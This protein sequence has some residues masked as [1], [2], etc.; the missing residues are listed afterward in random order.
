MSID[1]IIGT[2][3]DS[4]VQPR[5]VESFKKAFASIN[6]SS[7]GGLT[8]DGLEQLYKKFDLDFSE[9]DIKMVLKILSKNKSNKSVTFEEFSKVFDER[10]TEDDGEAVFNSTFD[11]CNLDKTA[12][13]F[14]WHNHPTVSNIHE[15][16]RKKHIDKD[17]FKKVSQSLGIQLK[18]KDA[19]AM[20]G[21]IKNRAGFIRLMKT[22]REELEFWEGGQQ[23]ISQSIQTTSPAPPPP[24]KENIHR[25]V[26]PKILGPAMHRMLLK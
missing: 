9:D 6:H 16:D 10:L 4:Y 26:K 19:K 25:G 14:T 2:N 21:V 15:I 7:Y 24:L 5:K 8:V 17:S 1:D 18:D 13:K 12:F 23:E 20:L 22:G 11:L 3:W